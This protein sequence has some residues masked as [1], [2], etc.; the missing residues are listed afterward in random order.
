M[1]WEKPQHCLLLF[2]GLRLGRCYEFRS[3]CNYSHRCG[4]HTRIAD[5]LSLGQQQVHFRTGWHW[6]CPT[7]GQL[8]VSSHRS[9]P[10]NPPSTKTLPCKHNYLP[11]RYVKKWKG[12]RRRGRSENGFS[13]LRHSWSWSCY[14]GSSWASQDLFPLQFSS[15]VLSCGFHPSFRR[16]LHELLIIFF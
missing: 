11:F 6:L 16:W 7:W 5:G 10:R 12:E 13:C 4:N 1:S 2:S 9:H 15:S 14:L 3:G 8:L